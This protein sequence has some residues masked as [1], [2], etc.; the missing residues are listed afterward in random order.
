MSSTTKFVF[1]TGGVVSSLGKGVST[2]SIGFILRSMGYKILIKKLDPYLNIDPGTMNPKEH[3]EVFVTKDGA[4]TDLDL[5]HYERFTG[6]ETTKD[7]NITSGRIYQNLLEKER[8]GDYLGKTVQVIPHVTD[9]I[10]DFII[11]HESDNDF[12][13]CEIGGTV[14]DIEALPFFEA[15]RQI[16][17]QRG[18]VNTMFIHLTL[19]PFLQSTKEVK[20]KPTQHSVKELMSIGIIPD[21]LICRSDVELDS[22]DRNKISSFCNV[23]YDCVIQGLNESNIYSIPLSYLSQGLDRV[24][25]RKFERSGYQKPD[26]EKLQ[27]LIEKSKIIKNKPLKKIAIAGK[28]TKLQDSYKSLSEAIYHASLFCEQNLDVDFI[29]TRLFD[30]LEKN[31]IIN[32]ISHYDGIIV[33]GGF[34]VEGLEGKIKIIQYLREANKPFLGICLGMQMCVIEFARNVLK[35]KD[36]NT[37]E[38]MGD[39]KNYTKI[40]GIM[41]Q[42]MDGEKII[43]SQ[44]QIGGSMRLGNYNAKVVSNT[45]CHK[46]YGSNLTER[47]RHRYELDIAFKEQLEKNGMIISGISIDE[48]LPE[49][50]EIPSCKFFIGVQFHPEFNSSIL[51]PNPLF[52]EFIKNL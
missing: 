44:K 9:L 31:E 27:N 23:D 32:K 52:V 13:I 10:K 15:I 45:L 36:A 3:G 41:N 47:H 38:V 11:N 43:N 1:V 19:I 18:K 14:G 7:S 30:N 16:R 5:G 4:E 25:M 48:R 40:I 33:P 2:A 34:G 24:L 8:R 50:V 28:Y 17:M 26:T 21:V 20:T 22:L 6:V 51:K 46:I 42:W 39:A 35:I 49:V 29:D 12:I 37:Q